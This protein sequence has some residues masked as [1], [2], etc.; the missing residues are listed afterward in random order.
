M[1]IPTCALINAHC[2]WKSMTKYVN[3][4]WDPSLQKVAKW[5]AQNVQPVPREMALSVNNVPGTIIQR[6]I[7]QNVF[8]ARRDKDLNQDQQIA[9]SS[10]IKNDR[11]NWLM[12]MIDKLNR[13]VT[14]I[15]SQWSLSTKS[16]QKW[17]EV[18]SRSWIRGLQMWMYKW[19]RRKKLR[20]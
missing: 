8:P 5:S 19:L 6:R 18:S 14:I 10:V 7:S 4:L 11:E 13:A 17:W 15:F 3:V 16:L 12:L 9:V 20:M 1:P 2:T